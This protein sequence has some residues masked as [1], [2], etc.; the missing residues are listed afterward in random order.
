MS[1]EFTELDSLK[2]I[3]EN[4][5]IKFHPSISVEKLKEKI[6]DFDAKAD[7]ASEPKETKGSAT[8][9]KMQKRNEL[10][11]EKLKLIRCR[12]TCMNPHKRD[13]QGEWMSIGNAVLGFHTKYVLFDHEY[14]LTQMMIDTLKTRVFRQTKDV[15]DG[16]GGKYRKNFFPK[17]YN[18]E[19]L[20]A[21]TPEELDALAADQAKRQAI[22]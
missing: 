6:A 2:Q 1:E 3:A 16:K 18:V 17:E 4:K 12:I 20:P 22:D 11:K 5:G 21:L 9:S 8:K 19:I 14:H 7:E 15:P 10:R 13:W